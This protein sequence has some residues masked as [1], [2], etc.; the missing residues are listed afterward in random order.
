MSVCLPLSSAVWQERMVDSFS[1][2]NSWMTARQRGACGVTEMGKRCVEQSGEAGRAQRMV[3]LGEAS[4]VGPW[5][6]FVANGAGKGGLG[7]YGWPVVFGRVCD[8]KRQRGEGRVV[9][10]FPHV[11]DCFRHVFHGT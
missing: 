10:C 5:H 9:D 4:G 1:K 8:T 7:S 2:S 11:F 3:T 6:I